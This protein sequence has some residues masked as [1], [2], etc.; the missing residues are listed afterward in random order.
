MVLV[1]LACTAHRCPEVCASGYFVPPLLPLANFVSLLGVDGAKQRV[2]ILADQ[3]K[4]HLSIFR[5][6]AGLLLQSVDFVLDRQ[7]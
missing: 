3:A 1:L 4:D 6:R 2:Q 5:N 7:K